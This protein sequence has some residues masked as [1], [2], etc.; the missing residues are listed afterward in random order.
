MQRMNRLVEWASD[1][2]VID[3]VTAQNH[4]MYVQNQSDGGK[5]SRQSIR[6]SD[7]MSSVIANAR[8]HA[9]QRWITLG[10]HYT[11]WMIDEAQ[12]YRGNRKI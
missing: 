2:R 7:E 11:S 10:M 6:T 3:N 8:L 9:V 5:T 4:A 12:G 1:E